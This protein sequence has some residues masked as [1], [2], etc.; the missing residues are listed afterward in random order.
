MHVTDAPFPGC[1][2]ALLLRVVKVF[3]TD[4]DA[5]VVR[6]GQSSNTIK[7]R[8]FSCPR[9]AEDNRETS[10]R[11]EVDIQVEAAFGIRKALAD[12]HFEFGRNWQRRLWCGNNNLY[13]HG[14]AIH[15][16]RFKPDRFNPKTTD[17]TTNEM[18]SSTSAVW[19]ALE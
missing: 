2:I 11:A 15:G 5:S 9:C 3:T 10:Q 17:N 18:T 14:P 6:I 12:T 7:Q 16:R 19:F 8:S 1:D 13:F 4:C